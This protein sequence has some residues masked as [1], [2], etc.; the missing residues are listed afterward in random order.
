MSFYVDV[1]GAGR[2]RRTMPQ[3]LVVA[4]LLVYVLFGA[5]IVG[6]VGLLLTAAQVGAPGGRV[7]GGLLYAAAPGVAGWLLARRVWTGGEGVR[8]GLIAVQAWLV[9][10]AL[11]TLRGGSV[12]GFTQLLL[13]VVILVFLCMKESREWF[14]SAPSERQERPPFS[15]PHMLTWRRDRGQTAVEYTG[16]VVLVAAIVAALVMSGVGDRIAGRLQEAVCSLVGRSC[17]ADGGGEGTHQ[18][19]G[20]A[21]DA[22]GGDTDGSTGADDG[23]DGGRD[24]TDG[25]ATDGSTGDPGSTGPDGSAQDDPGGVVPGSED[26]EGDG[27]GGDP[28]DP[29]EPI[30][31]S[32]VTSDGDGDGDGD[33]G[34][35]G[36]EREDCSG[37][38]GCTL[39]HGG[40]VL[41]GLFVDGVWGD[42]TDTWN[43]IIHPIDSIA[44]LGDY[45]G[46]LGDIWTEGTKDAGGKWDRGEYGDALTD[47]GG[48]GV[49][50]VLK[51]LDDMF[52]GDEVREAWNRGEETQA[53]TNVVWNV[54]SLFIPGYGEVKAA[55]KL[56]KLGRLGRIAGAVTEI[57]DRAKD[58]T[59]RARKAAEAGDAKGARDAADEAQEVADEAK[60]K[61]E[62]A[63][64]CKLV[65]LGGAL[66]VP[67]GTG[68]PRHLGGP[69]GSTVVLAAAP[70]S[71]PVRLVAEAPDPCEGAE[72]D[73]A[74]EAQQQADEADRAADAAELGDVA[75]QVKQTIVDGRDK[76][77]TAKA[78][79]FN[80]NEGG[81]DNLVAKAKDDPDLARGEY[82]KEELAAALRDLDAALRNKGIDSQTRGSLAATVLK[83]GNRHQLAEAMAEVRAA[84]RAASE[85]A[86]GTKVHGAVGA[87][88]GR[89]SVD[90]GD[91]TTVDVSGVDDVDVL[92]RGKD[93]DIH[94]VEVKN[95]A[96]AATKYTV[97]AQAKRLADWAGQGGRPPRAARYEIEQKKDW[98]KIFDGYQTD[99]KNNVT[100]EGTPARTFAEN[101]LGVR[102]A[103]QDFTPRQIRAMDDAW[104]AKSDAEK[105]AALDS[106]RMNDPKSAMEY[107]GV[108]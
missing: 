13:P 93:G 38:W 52:V 105:R 72:A 85:A 33:G 21:D 34:N 103:G 25:D 7:L 32:A 97:P 94:A 78:D 27:E 61:V 23:T 81:V 88:K 87:K 43:T 19:G 60:E 50:V 65:A 86:D 14:R 37:F 9:S 62:E 54:G 18:A 47:W 29:Y 55:A 10:G 64:G 15:L 6:G 26:G 68:A 98:H 71:V 11:A 42:L 16:L 92:Y 36:G 59:G 28:T 107:L 40:Q 49:D 106:G 76:Q 70:A 45:A 58:A 53:V 73:D 99:R 69:G 5:T 96:N 66:R 75:D 44:G 24:G 101:G 104:N 41:E 91:G 46:S 95:T 63:G 56:G 48:T 77:K 100:P 108:T 8:W 57:V 31:D 22:T 35:G 79:R 51:P 20:G 102:I 3:Q 1:V 67:Y 80:L 90:M 4:R 82:G 74:R 89:Q 12:Q 84:V 17:P 2:A 39:D 30:G 83:A